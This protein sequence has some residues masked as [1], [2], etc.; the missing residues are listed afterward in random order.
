MFCYQHFSQVLCR[1]LKIGLF[2]FLA[3]SHFTLWIFY[4]S[5]LDS[6]RLTSIFFN[7]HH[8]LLFFDFHFSH[9]FLSFILWNSY[10]SP[11]FILWIPQVLFY[12]FFIIPPLVKSSSSHFFLFS[13]TLFTSLIFTSLIFSFCFVY[14]QVNRLPQLLYPFICHG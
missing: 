14:F 2:Y 5:T 10:Y 3:F 12:C 11:S 8:P 4:Y 13:S 6:I 1:V 9:L 7:L